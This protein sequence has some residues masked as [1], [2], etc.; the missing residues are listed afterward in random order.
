MRRAC[1]PRR[2]RRRFALGDVV[3]EL[4]PA[5]ADAPRARRRDPGRRRH[6]RR[7]G[8][9][10][11][12]RADREAGDAIDVGGAGRRVRRLL[13]PAARACP[14]A[15]ATTAPL[16]GLYSVG[17]GDGRDRPG[18]R[19]VPDRRSSAASITTEAL[20]EEAAATPPGA[21]GVVFLP[22]LAGE[23]SP[24][25]DPTARGAFA[26]LTLGHGRGHL[27]AGD[28]RGVGARDPPRRRADARG[29]RRRSTTMRVCGGPARSELWNQVKADVTGFRV[30]VPAVLET[31]V[32]GRGD[33]S[34]RPGSVRTPTC[35]RRSAAMTRVAHRLE[36]RAELPRP[37]RRRVR[38]LSSASIRRSRRSSRRAAA[39][40]RRR[41]GPRRERPRDVL[42]FRARARRAADRGARRPRPRRPARRDR[43]AHRP[44]RLRQVARSCGSSP[45][46]SRPPRAAS[47]LDGA[48]ITGPDPRIGL[49]FQE[50]RLLP[51][52]SAADNITYPLELAGWPA[53]AARRAPRRA[54]RP[55][56]PRPTPADAAA[57]PS[58]RAGCASASR[59]PARSRSSP[60]VLLLDEPFSALDALTPRAVRPRAAGALGAGP[61][62]DRARHPQHPR[63]DPRRRPGRRAVAAARPGRGGRP[64]RPAAAALARRPRRGRSSRDAAARDPGHPRRGGSA[65]RA[66]TARRAVARVGSPRRSRLVVVFLLSGRRSS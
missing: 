24:I 28:R 5:A 44:Q 14:A 27:D 35:R 65:G 8:E 46:C 31:A 10:P 58:C 3:G 22:Y 6:R 25:W 60:R 41:A 51:W 30:A 9:L 48:P 62:D 26:G 52:R 7:V 43:R 66:M 16:P 55:R 64:G 56:R 1:P 17:G 19:L 15:F 42:S 21:D 4:T 38:R 13:G 37:L 45:G 61:A 33:R 40:D 2:S 59:S 23:R 36:P 57:R 12:R 18:A 53:R 34:G 20:L 63:G 54:A 50:P 11:R 47:T 29:R 39:R 49:V 32:L